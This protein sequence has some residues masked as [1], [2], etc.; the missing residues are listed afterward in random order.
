[1]GLHYNLAEVFEIAE[2]IEKNGAAFYRRAADI[3]ESDMVQK[4]LLLLADQ[5]EEHGLTSGEAL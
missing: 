2:Q 4:F 3:C 1:M 5:E